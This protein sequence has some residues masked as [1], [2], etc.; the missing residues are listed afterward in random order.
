MS[1]NTPILGLIPLSNLPF[2]TNSGCIN[3]GVT[4]FFVQNQANNS[5]KLLF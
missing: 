4:E 5:G 2:Y 3:L 1:G